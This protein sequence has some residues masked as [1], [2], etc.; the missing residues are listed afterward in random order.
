MPC[1]KCNE[2]ISPTK[3]VTCY[4]C[5]AKFHPTCTKLKTM[6]NYKSVKNWICELCCDKPKNSSV[7]N[8]CITD[9]ELIDF[10]D[11]DNSG[12]HI[13]DS[14]RSILINKV[15][16]IE[17]LTETVSSV[18]KSISFC[19]DQIDDFSVKLESVINKMSIME[20]KMEILESN[21]NKINKEVITLK[22]KLNSLEQA[23]LIYNLEISNFSKT[24]NENIN[25]VVKSVSNCLN[26]SL[27]NNDIIDS[28]RLKSND[29]KVGNI[30]V[31]LNSNS[32][33]NKIMKNIKLRWK[34][35][36][37]LTA[38]QAKE[39]SKK[40]GFKY[41]WANSGGVYIRKHEGGRCTKSSTWHYCNN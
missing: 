22:E 25:E 4:R 13:S 30:I 2:S 18:E 7:I 10:S 39:V 41:S 35:R 33:K 28:F 6:T 23:T 5:K 37:L 17:K 36:N 31:R 14:L 21:N 11:F 26:C 34:N 32:T 9:G 19:S 8:K 20:A 38:K 15:T 16:K 27:D 12:N 3:Q 29:N 40:Y 24:Q 1:I